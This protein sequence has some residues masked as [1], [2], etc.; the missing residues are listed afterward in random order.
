MEGIDYERLYSPGLS[1]MGSVGHAASMAYLTIVDS[2]RHGV[3]IVAK[4][5]WAQ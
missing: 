2:H 3:L 1:E 4:S 5:Q